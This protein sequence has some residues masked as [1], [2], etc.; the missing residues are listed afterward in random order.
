MFSS[1]S[2]MQSL[3]CV[4][5]WRSVPSVPRRVRTLASSKFVV[6]RSCGSGTNDDADPLASFAAPSASID[7][8]VSSAALSAWLPCSRD[9]C[10]HPPFHS[11]PVVLCRSSSS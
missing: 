10:R 6:T 1:V 4:L 8:R 7:G 9:G 5:L 3:S 11:C 2:S